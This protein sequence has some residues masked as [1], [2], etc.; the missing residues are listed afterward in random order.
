MRCH[1][2]LR[3]FLVGVG[4]A[5]LLFWADQAAKIH[6]FVA[7][8]APSG[9]WYLGGFVQSIA[10]Y[11][12][13]I[14]FNIPLPTVATLFITAL[15]LGWILTRALNDAR[16]DRLISLLFLGFIAGG[17]IGNAYDRATLSYVRDWLLLWHR[18]AIN[19]ADLAI[20]IGA[21][22]YF[23]TSKRQAMIPSSSPISSSERT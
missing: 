2:L 21:V 7:P 5:A 20:I 22:G 4:G 11:N 16:H 9:F 15:A 10:H 8:D 12:Y 23:V 14:T 17:A 18:S 13:G 3:F 6:W 1:A 19:L